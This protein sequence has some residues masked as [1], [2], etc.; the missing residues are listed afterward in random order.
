VQFD[1][2]AP[3]IRSTQVRDYADTGATLA[4]TTVAQLTNKDVETLWGKNKPGA[5]PTV[6]I[7]CEQHT[8]CGH[9]EPVAPRSSSQRGTV[10]STAHTAHG[11]PRRLG[12]RLRC[13]YGRIDPARSS[14]ALAVRSAVVGASKTALLRM[15]C[16]EG[17]N[18]ASSAAAR[19]VLHW[20]STTAPS[21][22]SPVI[23]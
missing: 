11:T 8:D 20:R 3:Y 17:A 15:R 13:P 1:R 7:H 10:P 16:R 21:A 6:A 23:R 9:W 2:E 19:C 14:V 4:T 22:K 5:S 12:Y 18:N